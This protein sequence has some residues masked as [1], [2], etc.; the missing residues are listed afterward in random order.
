MDELF[1]DFE[2][3]STVN[4]KTAGVYRYTESPSFRAIM[5]QYALGDDPVTVLEEEELYSDSRA[6]RELKSYLL[7]PHILKIAHNAGFDRIVAST[8]ARFER[9][10]YLHPAQWHDTMAV[11]LSQGLPASLESLGHVLGGEQKDTAGTRLKNLFTKLNRGRRIVPAERPEDWALFVDYGR[12]DTVTLRDVHRR[13]GGFQTPEE[14]ALYT[15]D[16]LVNDRGIRADVELARKAVAAGEAN[17]VAALGR[18]AELTGVE[19]PNSVDQ[20][21]GWLIDAGFPLPDLRAETVQLALDDAS[22]PDDIREVLELRQIIA[23]VAARKY[24]AILNGVSRDR[25][26]RGQFRFLGAHTGRWSGRGVQ[27]QNLPRATL[28][29]EALA[30]AGK[31][32]A[33]VEKEGPDALQE[34][35]GAYTNV[36]LKELEYGFGAS[37]YQ[38]KALIRPMFLGPLAVADYSAIEARCIAWEAGE[39][40][41]LEAF[42][43]GR[44]IYT[45]T[46]KRM[47]EGFTRQQGKVAVLALGYQGAVGSLRVMGATGSDAALKRMVTQYRDAN[48]AIV[49]F[50][51]DLERVF[52]TGGTAGKV[53]VAKVGADRHIMLPS[54]RWLVYKDVH[55]T[56][57]EGPYG[58]RTRASFWDYRKRY[59]KGFRVSTYGGRLAENV[60]QAV[61]RDILAEAMVRLERKSFRIVG[62]VHDEAI[63]EI[64]AGSNP[65]AE[66]ETIMCQPPSWA[67]DFPVSA[68]GYVTDRYR[69]D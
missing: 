62:H 22:T 49:G 56:T 2:T 52:R 1:I 57:E 64:P 32:K 6:T 11:A 13:M 60:T 36:V 15:V 10:R 7:D 68:H 24:Q 40:W 46:A 45:E 48:P 53:Y 16:Q 35:T 18:L 69:K 47:G 44:D 5:A 39:E 12:Q 25:R 21:R 26:L 17:R 28:E 33:E 54:G 19:N 27:L 63:V 42:R 43:A 20:L 23:L 3:F 58:P 30:A 61:A 41:A 34:L 8:L 38:L 67:P 29:G 37:P 65:L 14:R 51:R 59:G 55:F 4:L 66:V 31:T 9:A 50:W